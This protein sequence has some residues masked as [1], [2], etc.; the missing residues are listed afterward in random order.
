MNHYPV[1]LATRG[2]RIL[3]SGGGDAALAKLRLLMKTQA[4]LHV[5]SQAAAPEIG[6]WAAEGRLTLHARRIERSDVAGAA[7]L[8]AA[9]E[10]RD[11]DARTA[12]LGR[13]AGV[14]TNIVDDLSS[15]FYTPAIV[16][17]DPVTVA[18]G[19]EGTAP[20]LARRIKADLEERLPARLGALARMADLFRPA[21]SGFAGWRRRAL[22]SDW[23]EGRTEPSAAALAGLIERHRGAPRPEGHVHFVGAGPGDP[24]LL[25]LKARRVLHEADVVLHDRLVP[26]P[27][28]ELARRE[29][30]IVETGKTGFGPS[31][32]QA[33]IDALIVEHAGQGAQVVRLKAGDPTVFG[34]L[35][36]ETEACRSAGIAYS[37]V[38]GITAASAA[39][40]SIGA[41]LTRRGRNSELRIVTGHDVDGFADA[42]WRALAAP[43]AV[44]AI[45]MGRRAARLWQGRLLMHGADPATPVTVAERVG[46]ADAAFHVTTLSR[47]PEAAAVSGA[48]VI[49]LGLAPHEATAMEVAL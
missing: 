34:R 3:L 41:S 16:D 48:A 21:V 23:F 37:V 2:R 36:E 47:L 45:Y 11:E 32:R 7:L 33:E 49:L 35:D 13:S 9:D 20:V 14:L 39:A 43:G 38:P 18:I 27:V 4:R 46:H 22:W 15:D 10:D 8:Y 24:E 25:T 44:A 29:A 28:I 17:R 40:A 31:M 5:F 6:A 1:F 12:A 19:T 30:L 26:Q 42:D